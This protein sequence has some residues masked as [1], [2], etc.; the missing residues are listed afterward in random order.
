MG[1]ALPLS[2]CW[3]CPDWLLHLPDPSIIL[4]PLYEG[5]PAL[6]HPPGYG[7]PYG[8]LIGGVPRHQVDRHKKTG[9]KGR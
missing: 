3:L 5:S 8:A 6:P 2:P 9:R 7:V 1:P 4:R